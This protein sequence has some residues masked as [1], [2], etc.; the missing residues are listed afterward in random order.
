MKVFEKSLWGEAL[1]KTK[2]KVTAKAI[3]ELRNRVI[4]IKE[5]IPD[6]CPTQGAV[7]EKKR[8]YFTRRLFQL[9]TE[10]EACKEDLKEAIHEKLIK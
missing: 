8:W 4:E 10:L 9:R 1:S 7:S 5:K 6:Y 2:I 3:K